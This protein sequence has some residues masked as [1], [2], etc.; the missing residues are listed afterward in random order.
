MAFH[1]VVEPAKKIINLFKS[2]QLSHLD[3]FP[4]SQLTSIKNQANSF[5]NLLEKCENFEIEDA[6]P[7]PKA[8]RD[9]IVKSID[10]Q[11]QPIFNEL[12][13]LISYAT[14]QSQDFTRLETDA[15]A[16]TQAIKT[17]CDRILSELNSA[18]ENA[19]NVLQAIRDVAAEQGVGN[20][21]SHFEGEAKDHE[22]EA[23]KWLKRTIGTSI[24]L[25]VFAI[26][27]IFLHKWS[28]I[29]PADA[30]QTVQLAISKV[31]IFGVIAYMLILCAKNFMS[32]KHNAVINKHR[33][34]A[35]ATFTALAE[36]T[37]DAASSDIVLSHAA[38][39][40]FSPQD[41]G[42]T[43]ND[44]TQSEKVPGVQIMPRIGGIGSQSV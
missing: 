23:K 19:D 24:G 34:N 6:A 35:L 4:R 25:G 39:C 28:W 29:A 20:Q 9:Q 37:S 2:I 3:Y 14:A 10:S 31:L 22:T 36:A 21:A 8:A 44:N 27:S 17:D 38:S 16:A 40:I 12:F 15:R 26:I 18:K 42:Y 13:P 11:F 41:T 1:D 30:Y 5:L 7:S 43:K 33:Q 32:H